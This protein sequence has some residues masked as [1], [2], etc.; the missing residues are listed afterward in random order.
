MIYGSECGTCQFITCFP[1]VCM[2]IATIPFRM[3]SHSQCTHEQT[4]SICASTASIASEKSTAHTTAVVVHERRK[5]APARDVRTT[6]SWNYQQCIQIVVGHNKQAPA[7]YQP[8]LQEAS[9]KTADRPTI[10]Q[11]IKEALFSNWLES[12]LWF[13]R[14]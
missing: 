10:Q 2:H 5:D 14:P 13:A 6:S 8:K 4:F 9:K 7:I 11:T 12:Q 1:F 3:P